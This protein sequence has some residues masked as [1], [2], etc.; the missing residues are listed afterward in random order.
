M[1][2][3]QGSTTPF[4]S[5]V[6]QIADSCGASADTEMTTRAGISLNSAIRHFNSRYKWNWL[7]TEAA[8]ITVLAPFGVA[9]VTAS[10]SV[11][12]AAAPAGHGL[13]TD[14]FISGL[15]WPVGTRA[16]GFG[17]NALASNF[18]TT[19]TMPITATRDMYDLPTD[20]KAMY[21]ARMLNG[22]TPLRYVQRRM[23]DRGQ[24]S[25]QSGGN[26]F[27]YDLM[28]VGSKGKIRLLTPPGAAD[29]LQVRYHRNMATAAASSTATTLDIPDGYEPYLMAWAK[30]HFLT[31]KGEDRKAQATTWLSLAEDGL[32]T[33]LKDQTNLPD[34]GLS[35]TPGH[36]QAG[37]SNIDSLSSVRW[38]Y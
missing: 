3:F 36:A 16:S 31:D 4:V 6:Q 10:A 1:A 11:A 32:R 30:W 27:G 12:S 21:S 2:L 14:D 24:E 9:G 8:P 20:Y 28:M 37:Q 23:V 34:E 22:N 38:D 29:V 19:A 35:F 13:K 17:V 5:A 18:A 25:E 15:C 7:L 26:V 33:M